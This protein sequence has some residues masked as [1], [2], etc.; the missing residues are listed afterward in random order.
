MVG[1]CVIP[2]YCGVLGVCSNLR[3]CTGGGD[4]SSGT[5]MLNIAAN[6]FSA[7]VYFLQGM[8]WGWMGLGYRI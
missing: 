5:S 7:A 8:E 3:S 1:C 2:L 4:S 6:C